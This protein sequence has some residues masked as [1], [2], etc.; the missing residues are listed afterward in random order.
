MEA[1]GSLAVEIVVE[2]LDSDL[3]TGEVSVVHRKMT[4]ELVVRE[5]TRAAGTMLTLVTVITL[6]VRLPVA[7]TRVP[8]ESK[9][10][11]APVSATVCPSSMRSS[12]ATPPGTVR[13]AI[14]TEDVMPAFAAA[15]RLPYVG[16][17]T[18]FGR[19]L[20]LVVDADVSA[21]R[22]R[23][24]LAASC[25]GIGAAERIDPS[26]EDIFVALTRERQAA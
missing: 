1:M 23:G 7:V 14:G 21:E 25:Q 17:A 20:H 5:S 8:L 10:S 13:Y 16:E 18:I 3:R 2:S 12:S 19:Q 24:D 15:R 6:A 22:L 26:L 11:P 4:P 9:S